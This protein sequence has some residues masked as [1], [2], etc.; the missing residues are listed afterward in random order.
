MAR[1]KPLR[2]EIEDDDHRQVALSLDCGS[3]QYPVSLTFKAPKRDWDSDLSKLI[4]NLPTLIERI[5]PTL[6]FETGT[7]PVKFTAANWTLTLGD[8]IL[9]C[10]ASL[11]DLTIS[12][13]SST[14][15]GKRFLIVKEDNTANT[16]TVST[17]G[18][19]TIEG[20]SSKTLSAKW[21]KLIVESDGVSNW[22]NC[23]SGF[24]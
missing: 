6:A 21:D 11:G 1:K 23:G 2:V 22:L 10:D 19:D 20:S 5:T 13:P 14:T 15:A 17:F 18:N 9:I 16:V 8:C 4:L 12:L 3:T 7:D 24:T